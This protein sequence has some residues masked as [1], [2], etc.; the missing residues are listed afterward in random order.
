SLAMSTKRLMLKILSRICPIC[1]ELN[2]PNGHLYC[3]KKCGFKAD[4][5]LVAAWNIGLKSSMWSALPF[6]PKATHPPQKRGGTDSN[7]MLTIRERFMH[8]S[9]HQPLNSSMRHCRGK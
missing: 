7:K 8:A 3:C 2:K 1:G 4:R 9:T 5:H 6:S